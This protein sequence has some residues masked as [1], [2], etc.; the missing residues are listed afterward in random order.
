MRRSVVFIF[1][2]GCLM[3]RTISGVTQVYTGKK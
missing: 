2:P 3:E 1:V